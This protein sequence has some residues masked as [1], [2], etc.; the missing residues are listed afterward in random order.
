MGRFRIL[1]LHGAK[2]CPEPCQEQRHDLQPLVKGRVAK[3]VQRSFRDRSGQNAVHLIILPVFIEQLQI[4]GK[5]LR[6]LRILKILHCHLHIQ[7]YAGAFIGIDELGQVLPASCR[8]ESLPVHGGLAPEEIL[9]VDI[10][11]GDHRAVDPGIVGIFLPDLE[12][13]IHVDHLDTVQRDHV[14]ITHGLI[15]FRGIAGCDD[16]PPF[17]H[18]LVAEGLLLQE[19]QH[20][21]RK[22]LGH[23]VDLVNEQDPF[24]LAGQFHSVIHRSNDLAHGIFRH[25][26]SPS[27]VFLLRNKRKTHRALPGVMGDRIRDQR[28]VTLRSDLLHDLRLAD[29]G[30]AHQKHRP[31]PDLRNPVITELILLKIGRDSVHDLLFCPSDI[32][33]QTSSS[34]HTNRASFISFAS[35]S[36]SSRGRISRMAHGGTWAVS[37]LSS[38]KMN[39]VSNGGLFFG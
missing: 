1:C 15:V 7:S 32:H 18:L 12:I 2:A 13:R 21:R 14:K 22:G 39:A 36:R 28:Q 30:R 35:T 5:V 8:Y 24:L 25:L 10:Q 31:L 19:L 16:D 37:Q 33:S 20:G 3:P 38:Q 9:P 34:A 11:V 4:V 17:R 6:D 26:I 27:A 29:P 23:T